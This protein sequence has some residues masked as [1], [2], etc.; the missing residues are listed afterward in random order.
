LGLLRGGITGTT[1]AIIIIKP[2]TYQWRFKMK[3]IQFLFIIIV[4]PIHLLCTWVRRKRMD[5]KL[6][7]NW[8]KLKGGKK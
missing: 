6:W 5:F 7:C 3:V 1:Q 8:Q 4:G 2:D